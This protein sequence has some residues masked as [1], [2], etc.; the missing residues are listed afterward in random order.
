MTP[1]TISGTVTG[2]P[3][4]VTISFSG[5]VSSVQTNGSGFYTAAGVAPG[6]YTVTPSLATYVFTPTSQSVTVSSNGAVANF[7]GAVGGGVA[8]RSVK[9]VNGQRLEAS[10]PTTVGGIA[11]NA[12]SAWRWT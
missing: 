8:A 12:M 3:A 11:V 1:G 10:I 7:A 6:T 4:G 5:G 2:T 9:L